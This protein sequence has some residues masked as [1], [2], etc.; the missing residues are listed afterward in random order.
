MFL[1]L[2][3]DPAT[4]PAAVLI[5]WWWRQGQSR[6][7]TPVVAE[8]DMVGERAGGGDNYD[9]ATHTLNAAVSRITR[10]PPSV[11]PV[12]PRYGSANVLVVVVAVV[13]RAAVA[14][15]A[16]R[17]RRHRHGRLL[18]G[19]LGGVSRSGHRLAGRRQQF[20]RRDQAGRVRR[21]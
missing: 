21:R 3:G 18:G 13:V 20:L 14:V 5:S 10:T 8:V 7:K 19:R 2:S 16:G 1:A 17:R 6:A 12:A 4:A 15:V 9:V 11:C